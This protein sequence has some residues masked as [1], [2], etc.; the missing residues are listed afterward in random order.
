MKVAIVGLGAA[1]LRAA[2]LL[3]AAGHQVS[4]FEARKRLGGRIQTVKLDEVIYDA[5]G[6]WLD[7]DHHLAL[8]LM[9][10]LGLEP[11]RTS[12]WPKKVIFD[13]QQC[14]EDTLWSEALEDE[15]RVDGTAR[16]MCRDLDKIPW[17]NDHHREWDSR[18][19]GDFLRENTSS[20]R[21]LWW[22]WA[23]YRSDEGDDP[24]RISLLG[25]LCGYLHY[26]DRESH[27]MSAY[28][29]PGGMGAMID[30][31]AD[32]IKAKP[33]LGS[34]LMRVRQDS[35]SVCLQF[36]THEVEADIAILTIPPPALEKVVFEPA[37]SGPKRC[38]I[39]ACRMSRAIKIVW[40]FDV[41]WW[42]EEGWN[43]SLL[44][45]GPL[46]QLWDATRGSAPLL[47]AY[48]CGEE[49]EYWLSQPEPAE[50][51]REELEKMFPAA[52]GHCKRGWTH[53]WINDPLSGGAFSHLGPGYVLDFMEHVGSVEGRVHFAGEHTGGRT[54]FIEG[55]LESAERVAAE[56]GDA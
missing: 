39:E 46:Q 38:A 19:L 14:W 3:E 4:L 20:K 45:N 12:G 25:W 28:R 6:E 49:A 8:N 21:G 16:D 48:A 34:V 24:D 17:R 15:I 29:V 36:D 41:L 55:S 31:M 51:A 30:G 27:S 40:E 11:D 52:K 26:L 32:K 2:M 9:Q 22:V 10:E 5:G 18:T 35:E 54:G 33:H 44:C 7:A 43:G 23:N 37:L 53:D 47:A 1:G 13:S 56:I 50:A 42:K